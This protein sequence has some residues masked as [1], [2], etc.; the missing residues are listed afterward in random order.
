MQVT[1]TS[2]DLNKTIISL[3]GLNDDIL[4]ETG[5]KIFTASQA[6]QKRIINYPPELPMQKYKRTGIYGRSWRAEA[7]RSARNVGA[8]LTGNAVQRGRAYTKYVGGNA[9]GGEQAGIHA[10]R[11]PLAWEVVK[12]EVNKISPD[13]SSALQAAARR[14]GL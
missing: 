5:K 2:P 10:G 9:Q 3:R 14:R 7:T 4:P 13:I 12:D 1:I 6:A 11:W 8:R